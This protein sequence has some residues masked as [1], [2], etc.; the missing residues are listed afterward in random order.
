MGASF[1]AGGAASV[2]P[3]SDLRRA[4]SARSCQG[5]PLPIGTADLYRGLAEICI[6]R[7]E[8]EAA[9][10]HLH[11]GQ[12]LGEQSATTDWP[13]R[14]CVS[15]ARL[16]E[17]QGDLDEALALLDE[18]ERVFI[19]GPLPDIR[20]AAALKAQV[21][22]KKGWLAEALG[23]ACEQELS[24]DDD[25][26]YTREFEHI[27]LARVLIAQFQTDPAAGDLQAA[28]RLLDRLLQAAE[29]GGRNG[30]VIA[31]LILQSLASQAQSQQPH[32]LATL[33]RA[34]TLAEPEG[35]VRIFVDEGEAI[36]LLIEQLIK[37][38]RPSAA[39][40]CGQT[41]GCLSTTAGCSKTTNQP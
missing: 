37:Q 27:T 31:I 5:E 28:S 16:K 34:L 33:E 7:G 12:K 18:A 40:L 35:F 11:T 10:Q 17:A 25:L 20:P 26:S 13:H 15:K 21:W 3:R 38:S 41:P 39:R 22:L 1:A 30:S 24:A 36:R 2:S 23:W 8:L 6:E 19:R 4:F 9:A 32:A 14:L 29:A